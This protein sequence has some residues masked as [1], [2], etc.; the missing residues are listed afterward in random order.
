MEEKLRAMLEFNLLGESFKLDLIK[1]AEARDAFIENCDVQYNQDLT[2]LI[3]CMEALQ[4]NLNGEGLSNTDTSDLTSY[5]LCINQWLE[6]DLLNLDGISKSKLHKKITE[7]DNL[8]DIQKTTTKNDIRLLQK[9]LIQIFNQLFSLTTE[10]TITQDP[11]R[12][13]NIL[14]CYYNKMLMKD[15]DA[16]F[17]RFY[18]LQIIGNNLKS[19]YLQYIEAAEEDCNPSN[20]QFLQAINPNLPYTQ[21]DITEFIDAIK[22]VDKGNQLLF[23]CLALIKQEQANSGEQI[24]RKNRSSISLKNLPRI[25]SSFFEKLEKNSSDGD[26]NKA[27]LIKELNATYVPKSRYSKLFTKLKEYLKKHEEIIELPALDV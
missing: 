13:K 7:V 24:N 20:L 8:I 18:C 10:Q 21:T 15:K 6:S 14:F 3:N 12:L 22:D 23:L 16:I 2:I 11:N 4:R 9:E 5:R 19:A 1:D 26:K 25:K 27:R 17:L